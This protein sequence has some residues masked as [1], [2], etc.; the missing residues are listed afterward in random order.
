M[1]PPGLLSMPLA[2]RPFATGRSQLFPR[3]PAL[4]TGPLLSPYPGLQ[5]CHQLPLW[6]RTRV[7]TFLPL[8]P[9][10]SGPD[11]AA[12]GQGGRAA[13]S[14][15][16]RLTAGGRCPQGRPGRPLGVGTSQGLVASDASSLPSLQLL[17]FWNSGGRIRA[18]GSRAPPAATPSALASHGFEPNHSPEFCGPQLSCLTL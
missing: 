2:K 13:G 8:G 4:L 17:I 18:P 11:P 10:L 7:C 15:P 3:G 9:R 12:P 14:G 5:T 1:R 16:Q 6:A